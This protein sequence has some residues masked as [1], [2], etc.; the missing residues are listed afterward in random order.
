MK[1]TV[2]RQVTTKKP[3]MYG[4]AMSNFFGVKDHFWLDVVQQ[5]YFLQDFGLWIVNSHLPLEFVE[6]V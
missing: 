1:G 2:N 4:S 3:N 5:K 6:N